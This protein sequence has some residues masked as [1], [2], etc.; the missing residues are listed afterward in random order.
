MYLMSRRTQVR[1]IEA[2][3]WATNILNRAKEVTG[4]EIQ[5][6]TNAYSAG[7][8]T[9]TWTSWWADLAALEAAFAKLQG[10]GAYLEFERRRS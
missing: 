6:W 8:G 3:E 5:L 1:S 10:D 7:L 9:I 2:V 4:N